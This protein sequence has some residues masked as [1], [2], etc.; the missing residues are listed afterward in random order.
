MFYS[1]DLFVKQ[2]GPLA[3]VWLA[4]HQKK[5]S[6][7]LVKQ[8]RITEGAEAINDPAVSLALRVRGQL[9]LGL[10]RLYRLQVGYLYE[11]ASEAV[12]RVKNYGTKSHGTM[13]IADDQAL[14]APYTQITADHDNLYEGAGVSGGFM[15]DVDPLEEQRF[16]EDMMKSSATS[17]LS[18]SFNLSQSSQ[19]FIARVA[20]ITLEGALGG[21]PDESLLLSQSLDDEYMIENGLNMEMDLDIDESKE[22][23]L[24]PF[25][26]SMI[27]EQ[28]QEQADQSM[29]DFDV[30]GEV[31]VPVSHHEDEEKE[32]KEIPVA[33][34]ST[35][36]DGSFP[37]DMSFFHSEPLPAIDPSIT[38][39]SQRRKRVNVHNANVIRDDV[40][41]I[42]FNAYKEWQSDSS[43]LVTPRDAIV[44]T[45]ALQSRRRLIEP[46]QLIGENVI[47]IPSWKDYKSFNDVSEIVKALRSTD[48]SGPP[49]EI[50]QIS[51]P[52]SAAQNIS[53]ISE[54]P[55][56]VVDDLVGGDFDL[57]I[58]HGLHEVPIHD[59][60]PEEDIVSISHKTMDLGDINLGT[61]EHS[62]SFIQPPPEEID[63]LEPTSSEAGKNI[64]KDLVLNE[65][66]KVE[67]GHQ[68]SFN[69][70][71]EG[72]NRKT[73]ASAF[74]HLLLL[75]NLQTITFAQQ[76]HYADI[77]I[78]IITKS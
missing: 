50:E 51:I 26:M 58:E 14:Q 52:D 19:S 72:Q 20:E 1:N 67:S 39:R 77:Y 31:D 54:I 62:A 73:A 27:E 15:Y 65:L 6:R 43:D 36:S 45:V 78:Y 35:G 4:C 2:K 29:V 74:Y 12:I 59:D 25:D 42:P 75:S 8:T 28:K 23:H 46:S 55:D 56:V 61:R 32:E 70:L 71:S 21:V 41:E 64:G 9:L 69:S 47:D 33:V 13:M 57:D 76:I 11:D 34:E 24:Q 22:Q 7:L 30:M 5:L 63:E 48:L 66:A 49:I 3:R 37:T 68:L 38:V 10:V 60:Y 53:T 40:L 44:M 17:A 18:A 16:I